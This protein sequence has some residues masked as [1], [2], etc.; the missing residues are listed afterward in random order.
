MGFILGV[1]WSAPLRLTHKFKVEPRQPKN[2]FAG[3]TATV[4][5]VSLCLLDGS[6]GN[7]RTCEDLRVWSF[8]GC[9]LMEM[10]WLSKFVIREALDSNPHL[11]KHIVSFSFFLNATTPAH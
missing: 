7:R 8:K 1:I 3:T 11:M 4:N 6:H 9:V 10:R 5:R 2:G